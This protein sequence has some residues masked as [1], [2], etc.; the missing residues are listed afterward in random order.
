MTPLTLK[1]VEW[2]VDC[3]RGGMTHL[4]LAS[5]CTSTD[6]R[7]FFSLWLLQHVLLYCFRIIPVQT[8]KLVFIICMYHLLLLPL[9]LWASASACVSFSHRYLSENVWTMLSPYQAVVIHQCCQWEQV[10]FV[11]LRVW[12]WDK[13]YSTFMQS[14]LQVTSHSHIHHTDG[15]KLSCRVPAIRSPVFCLRT[16]GQ[17]VPGIELPPVISGRPT[18]PDR[19]TGGGRLG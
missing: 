16:C 9:S 18:L 3:K 11:S 1:R 13:L 15:S 7:Q 14:L 19:P 2:V 6:L 8:I 12:D 5:Q 10:V 4:C 17:E